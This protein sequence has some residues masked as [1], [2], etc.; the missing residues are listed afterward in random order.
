MT[1]AALKEKRGAKVSEL[2]GLND[3]ATSESR[4]L[5]EGERKRF[6]SLETEARALTD[7]IDRAERIAEFERMETGEPVSGNIRSQD[8][9]DY[10]LAKALD[11]RLNGSLS[12]LEREAHDELSRGRESRGLVVPVE[13]ILEKRALTTTAPVA[14]PGGNLVATN[15]AAMT[16]RRRPMLKTEKMGAT[17]L[18]GLTG[19]LDLPRLKA[20]GTAGWVA[21]HGSSSGSDPQFSKVSMGPKTVSGKYELS[22]RMRLQSKQAVEGILRND[23]GLLLSQALDAAAINGGGTNEPTGII[24]DADVEEI[25]SAVL[26]SDLTNA[27]I[28]ALELDDVSGTRAFMGHPLIRKWARALKDEDGHVIKLAETFHDEK[29]EST[30]QVPYTAATNAHLIY[31]EWASLYVGYWS[32]VDI[33][34]NPYAES[35][36]DKGG[37][38]LHAFLD[39]DVVVRHPEAFKFCDVTAS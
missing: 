21:E 26:S 12:G 36:A 10:S 18:R 38:L 32:G 28:A 35:V 1:L 16:D 33:L 27:M 13:I 30:T 6:E 17:V 15:L 34:V 31:G 19:N 11:E 20:S 9:S 23:L 5:D 24:A 14:G 29:L 22:R 7:Q 3:K 8:L 39:A 2:R 25:T 37:A 4:D